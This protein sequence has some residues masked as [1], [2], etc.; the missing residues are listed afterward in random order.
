MAFEQPQQPPAFLPQPGPIPI[1]DGPD[2]TANQ[3][4]NLSNPSSVKNN[5]RRPS[6]AKTP[7]AIK[8]STS[9]P[10]MRSLAQSDSGALS[11][12][13]ADKRARHKLGYQRT[14]VACGHCRRRK[15]RCLL[16]PEDP[17]GRCSNCIR[18]KKECNFYPVD[19]QAPNGPGA[20][21]SVK[22]DTGSSGATTSTPSPKT[23]QSASTGDHSDDYHRYSPYTSQGP[24]YPLA[25]GVSRAGEGPLHTP[26]YEYSTAQDP[27]YGWQ[28]PEYTP[29]SS[30]SDSPHVDG[31]ASAFWRLNEH[32]AG[33]SAQQEFARRPEVS[34]E[35]TTMPGA[36]QQPWGQPPNHPTWPPQRSMSFPHIENLSIPGN[37]TPYHPV[38]SPQ[39]IRRQSGYSYS[40]VDQGSAGSSISIPGTSNGSMGPPV[41][42]PTHGTPTH[43]QFPYKQPYSPYPPQVRQGSLPSQSE[44]Y[45]GHW[46]SEPSPLG[47]V[48]EEAPHSAPPFNMGPQSFFTGS[49]HSHGP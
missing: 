20:P 47:Q 21:Q 23:L 16:A 18:L 34:S 31:P 12:T 39:D 37:M 42:T 5:K 26:G 28:Q 15:I 3:D 30:V 40:S 36:V 25:P 19:Q 49:N 1:G 29:V 35:Q 7:A 2:Q 9:T 10:H 14:S 46:Y 8:R 45:S 44:G 6:K 48:H 11:P 32:P 43:P 13:A 33:G 17:Q 22:G 38:Q 4:I 41:Q 24:G 27:R